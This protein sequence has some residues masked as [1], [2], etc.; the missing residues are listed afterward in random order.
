MQSPPNAHLIVDTAALAANWRVFANA[1]GG[2]DCG[3]AIKADGYGLG[4]RAVADTLVAAGCR[5]L[6]VA[7]WHEVAA[8]ESLP[9]NV[10]I[11]V[12]HGVGPAE[13]PA[14]LASRAVPVL[15]TAAQVAAWKP[16]RRPCD[17][18]VDTGMNRLGLSPAE[19]LSGLLDGLALETLHSHLACAETPGHSLNES[20]RAAFADLA[21]RIPAKRYALAN[22]A[23]L[24]LGDG[25][26]F[27]LSRPGIG[28]YGGGAAPAGARLLP[29]AGIAAR[30]LQCRDVAAG[31]TIGY[32]ATFTATRPM[33]IAIVALGYADGYPRSLSNAGTALADDTVCPGVGRIS[34]DLAAF[35]V[36][37]ADPRLVAED[38]FLTIDFDLAR[39]AAESGRT[40]YELLT[41]LG[42]RYARIYR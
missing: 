11:R 41:G 7:H 23:G 32:G 35:D 25:Y 19:A 37:D 8:L 3:A 38:S 39:T 12:L 18:M 42:A 14:A 29:V 4:A 28:L 22:S 15:V 21:A 24:T 34:M 20:Q 2:A 33:R 5:D 1:S 40:E 27:S 26:R 31:A 10:R 30:I 9:A 13:M 16:S 17:V 36:T 6:F